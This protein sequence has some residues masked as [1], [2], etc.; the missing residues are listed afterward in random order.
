MPVLQIDPSL[1][2]RV[3]RKY[4]CSKGHEFVEDSAPVDN[5]S[6]GFRVT[7]HVGQREEVFCSECLLQLMR[8]NA[9]TVEE[10]KETV[11]GEGG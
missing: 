8:R 2:T 1:M 9:G 6:T 11:N 10:V 3:K 7:V 5:R 4:R